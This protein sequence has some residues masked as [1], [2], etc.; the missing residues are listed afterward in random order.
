MLWLNGQ[1]VWRPPHQVSQ[2]HLNFE[3]CSCDLISMHV[4][5]GHL[6]FWSKTGQLVTK[7]APCPATTSLVWLLLPWRQPVPLSWEPAPPIP[8]VQL[9][10]IF[11][12]MKMIDNLC[13]KQE[14]SDPKGCLEVNTIRSSLLPPTGEAAAAQR[15]ETKPLVKP[16]VSLPTRLWTKAGLW[17]LGGGAYNLTVL[18]KVKGFLLLDLSFLGNVTRPLLI[19]LHRKSPVTTVLSHSCRLTR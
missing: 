14:L 9:C 1:W 3:Q 10:N 16:L 12:Q 18:H 8:L 6:L 19:I 4:H 5:Y 15:A 7:I 17:P 11:S 13:T 2:R